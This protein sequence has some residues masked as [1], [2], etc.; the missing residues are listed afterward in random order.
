MQNFGR[1][2]RKLTRPRIELRKPGHRPW[3]L[4]DG[5]ISRMEHPGVLEISIALDLPE[6]SSEVDIRFVADGLGEEPISD[7]PMDFDHLF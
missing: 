6:Y 2:I 3:A 4:D 7:F 1:V 5:I